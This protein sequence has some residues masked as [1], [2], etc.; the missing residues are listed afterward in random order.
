M[1]RGHLATLRS[2][3]SEGIIGSPINS[4]IVASSMNTRSKNNRDYQQDNRVCTEFS[5]KNIK[6]YLFLGIDFLPQGT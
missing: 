3:V 4:K 5:K 6:K 1:I 2:D